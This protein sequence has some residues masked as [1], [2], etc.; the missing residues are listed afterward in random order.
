MISYPTLLGHHLVPSQPAELV[1]PDPRHNA[2]QQ[3]D[4]R[5]DHSPQLDLQHILIEVRLRRRGHG[6]QHGQQDDIAADAVV[7]VQL[8]G[9]LHAAVQLRHEVLRDADDGLDDGEDVRDQAEDGVRRFE[10]RAV[11]RELVVLDHDQAGDGAEQRDVVERRVRVGAFLL[12]LCRVRGLEDK[13]ALDE[14]EEGGGVEKLWSSVLVMLFIWFLYLDL[15]IPDAPR[16][17][18]SHG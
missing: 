11:V 14:E 3:D 8:L 6:R 5:D 9:V 10:V 16:I 4:S 13:D 2:N 12:L 18:S 15:D 1:H 7:L 17:E